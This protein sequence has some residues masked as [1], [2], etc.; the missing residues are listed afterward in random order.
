MALLFAAANR[1]YNQFANP[2]EL[3]LARPNAT[4]HLAFGKGPHYCKGAP[5]ARLEMKVCLEALTQRVPN[6]R[7]EGEVGAQDYPPNLSL[8]G[9]RRCSSARLDCSGTAS[10]QVAFGCSGFGDIEA[11]AAN[12]GMT[13]MTGA[14]GG[15]LDGLR[16]LELGQLL[17][18]PFAGH[19]VADMGA[20]VIKIEPPGRGD[21]MREWGLHDAE[22][23]WVVVAFSCPQQEVRQLEPVSP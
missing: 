21:P 23:P 8:R 11:D 6:L 9:P 7:L 22:G 13:M 1:D 2:D 5:L 18:G 20:E 3:D 15:V 14:S 16:V 4:E 19:L 12:E 10:T 17:A